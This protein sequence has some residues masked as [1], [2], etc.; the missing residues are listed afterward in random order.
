MIFAMLEINLILIKST[1]SNF[2]RKA[3]SSKKSSEV[4]KVI[5]FSTQMVNAFKSTQMNLI[6]TLVLHQND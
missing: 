2:Y 4:W 1:K 6:S 5:K 3:L